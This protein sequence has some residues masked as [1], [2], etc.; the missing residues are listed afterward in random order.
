[1]TELLKCRVSLEKFKIFSKI[2]MLCKNFGSLAN[3]EAI[4]PILFLKGQQYH[5]ISY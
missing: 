3:F 1:L 5:S 4:R 2:R